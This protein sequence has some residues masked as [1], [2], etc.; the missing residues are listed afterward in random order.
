MSAIRSTTER[1]W[2]MSLPCATTSAAM[3]A[4]SK[5]PCTF[6]RSPMLSSYDEAVLSPTQARRG[7]NCSSSETS[8]RR[9]ISSKKSKWRA[10][11]SICCTAKHLDTGSGTI[12]SGTFGKSSCTL[13]SPAASPRRLDAVIRAQNAGVGGMMRSSSL[14]RGGCSV[15]GV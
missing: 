11:S 8:W 10:A 4:S 1:T 15:Q 14:W 2:S 9:P 6:T 3:P 5:S 13:S 12:S 7:S